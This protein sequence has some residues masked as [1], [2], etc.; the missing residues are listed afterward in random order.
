MGGFPSTRL[1]YAFQFEQDGKREIIIVTDRPMG[2]REAA[3]GSR[4][5]EYDISAIEMVLEKKGDKEEGQG[6]LLAA[7]KLDYDEDKK[8]LEVE[9]LGQ[10]P[11][12]LSDIKRTK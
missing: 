3:S 9:A 4:S 12:K 1:H 8:K 10:Q 5:T 2:M 11:I 6:T 7:V